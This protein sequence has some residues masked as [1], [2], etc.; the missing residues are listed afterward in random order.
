M[1]DKQHSILLDDGMSVSF[2]GKA[3]WSGLSV[4]PD[5]REYAPS[6]AVYRTV[7][8]A[9]VLTRSEWDPARGVVTKAVRMGYA[10]EDQKTGYEAMKKTVVSFLAG[11]PPFAIG[12]VL[13]ALGVATVLIIL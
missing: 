9:I 10:S 5:G 4:R 2:R 3:L 12:K 6:V 13:D 8:G 7:A 11:K 1:R